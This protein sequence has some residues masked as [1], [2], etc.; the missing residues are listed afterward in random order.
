MKKGAEPLKSGCQCSRKMRLARFRL[1]KPSV[2]PSFDLQ[3]LSAG[4]LRSVRLARRIILTPAEFLASLA[5]DA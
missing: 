2:F 4:Q 5:D 1:P 3:V